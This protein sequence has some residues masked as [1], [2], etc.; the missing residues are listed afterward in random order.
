M[1][2]VPKVFPPKKILT[3]F[4]PL[5]LHPKPPKK[6]SV[7]KKL[8]ESLPLPL[9]SK[10][11]YVAFV[12]L[13]DLYRDLPSQLLGPSTSDLSLLHLKMIIMIFAD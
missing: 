13:L 11:Q 12:L 7:E 5:H 10:S 2:E 3:L 8:N 1:I 6:V 4:V 9:G